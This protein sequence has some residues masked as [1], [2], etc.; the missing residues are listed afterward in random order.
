[1]KT[2]QSTAANGILYIDDEEKSLKYF[3]AI[4]GDIAPIYTARSPEEGFA[5][6]VENKDRLALVLSDKKM[7]NESGIDLLKRIREHDP[8][9]FRILVTAFA[10]LNMAVECLNDGLLYS[11]LTKPWDP[12]ELEHRL[13]RA[14]R[15]FEVLRE[16][17]QLLEQKSQIVE[18]LVMADKA[19][20]I[21]I[22]SRGLNHHLRN[23]LTVMRT[24]FDMLPYQIE[25]E[26]GRVPKESDFWTEYLH[27]AGV[28][29]DRMTRMLSRLAEGSE[30]RITEHLEALN[31]AEVVRANLDLL[32]NEGENVRIDLRVDDEDLVV[33]AEP[34]A[35]AQMVRMLLQE[36]KKNLSGEG[37]VGIDITSEEGAEGVI[38]TVCDDGPT[39]PEKERQHLFDPFFVRSDKPEELGM[40]LLACYMTVF[41]HGGQICSRSDEDGR[42]LIEIRLPFEPPSDESKKGFSIADREEQFRDFTGAV[43]PS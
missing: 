30:N 40:N 9:P 27:E 22:L 5:C 37:T 39:I 23:S 4:F 35:I 13:L 33:Q 29:I 25:E 24:F 16:R 17:E 18:Q 1:M 7:P 21:G 41:R 11:Y 14:L 42:N 20:G 34:T 43:L 36:A 10:D 12:L 2:D 31:V 15:H 28:Q 19:S 32:E 8:A 6:F 3:Q 26:F 38:L